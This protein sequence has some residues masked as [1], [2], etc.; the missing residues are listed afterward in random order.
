MAAQDNSIGNEWVEEGDTSTVQYDPSSTAHQRHRQQQ[1]RHGGNGKKKRIRNWTANDRAAHRAFERSRREAFKERLA[2]LAK[3]I[4]SLKDIDSNKLSKHVVLDE[5]ITLHGSQQ[6]KLSVSLQ[7]VDILLSERDEILTELNQ[8]RIGAGL[9]LQQPRPLPDMPDDPQP[10][11]QQTAATAATCEGGP[12]L[13]LGGGLV[14]DRE[15]SPPSLDGKYHSGG[16][17]PSFTVVD[18]L[19]TMP[20]TAS[21]A[22]PKPTAAADPTW[23][24]L[25]LSTVG[26][27]GRGVSEL[28]LRDCIAPA[29]PF[30]DNSLEDFSLRS[31]ELND[32]PFDAEAMQMQMSSQ[33][34]IPDGMNGGRRQQQ[35]GTR[36]SWRSNY[37]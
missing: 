19:E 25:A 12:S 16:E 10:A 28:D 8:W 29:N 5:S 36:I 2:N 14:D 30:V 37:I 13:P 26:P 15:E 18:G 23:D 3:L 21:A 9:S 11:L 22:A 7:Q 6:N 27:D 1:S 34:G 20:T 31:Y 17:P 35:Q 24:T 33:L 32:M 4:P